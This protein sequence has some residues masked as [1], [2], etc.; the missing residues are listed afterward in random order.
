[1]CGDVFPAAPLASVYTTPPPP[2]PPTSVIGL[3]EALRLCSIAAVPT[4][5]G[6][7]SRKRRHPRAGAFA[8]MLSLLCFTSVKQKTGTLQT[9]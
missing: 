9:A 4:H 1:M 6:T 3:S 2:S 7:S 5:G 8:R